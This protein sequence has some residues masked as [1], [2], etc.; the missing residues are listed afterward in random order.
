[1]SDQINN[2]NVKI[3]LNKDESGIASELL[4]L[5]QEYVQYTT[6]NASIFQSNNDSL[7]F[8]KTSTN[9][10]VRIT[11]TDIESLIPTLESMGFDIKGKATEYHFVEGFM[12]ISAI[13][14]MESLT[15]EGMM[16][17]LPVRTA[18]SNVGSVTSQADFVHETERVRA[19]LPTGYDGT[20]VSIGVMSDS[21]NTSGNGSAAQDIVSGDLPAAGVTVL[22]EGPNNSIDEGRAMLQLVHDLAPG[23]PLVFSSVFFGEANFAQ[24]IRDLANPTIGNAQV[25][26]DD[27]V[28]LA[29]PFFQ[30][31]II[32][33]AVDDV[34]TNQGV[35]YFS[36]AGNLARQA[37]ESTNFNPSNDSAGIF[38]DIFHDFNPGAGVDT[39]QLITIAPFSTVRLSLQWDDPF[40]TTNGVDTDLGIFLLEPGTGNVLEGINTNNIANQTPVEIL[41]YTNTGFT[42]L[43]AEIVIPL[44]DGPAPGRIKF[45]NF[46]EDINFNEFGTNSSTIVPHAAAVNAMAVG[47][48]NYY[49]QQ[50]PADF[51]SAGPTTIL[52]NPDGTRKATPEVRLKPDFAAIQDTDTTFFGSDIDGNGFPNFSGTSAA[53]PHAA[54]IA[55]LIQQANPTFTPQ[56]IY[57]RLQSTAT[58]IGIPGRDDLTGVG[59]INAYDAVFGNVIP[60]TLDFNDNFEDG[61]LPIAYETRTTGAGRIQ[62]TGSNAPIGT[63]H[64][65]LDSSQDGINSLN[66]LILHV[67]ATGRSNVELSFAQK[68]FDDEDNLMPATFTGSVNADGVALSVDGTSWFRLFDLT[69]TNSTNTYQNKSI[70]LS[71]FATT[72]GLT[73][74]SDVQI[75][76]QQFDNF[77]TPTDGFAFDNIAVTAAPPINN[78]ELEFSSNSYSVNEDGTPVQAVTISRI[79]GSDGAVSVTLTPSNGTATAPADY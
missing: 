49:D 37:Y 51:T 65:V 45:V 68:E 26:V 16:G 67:N 55:A 8:D 23:S 19:A 76:F 71:Q 41:S 70:N 38:P 9:V 29:E 5:Q 35:T 58:D 50:N 62:V 77:S 12:P 73:L 66:E 61:D 13:S 32:A 79:G 64:V 72:N 7:V 60:A 31:G 25:L 4:N 52:F 27:I 40:Y 20:G 10:L 2:D 22:Q 69:G 36:A 53:A 39:R 46:G 3:S 74:G 54:A 1:M 17:V 33:Q 18:I 6:N 15:S 43:Q 34:V 63:S 47:A 57:N 14:E 75:K 78:G 21:Y 56:Q 42:E 24:Q 30:D 11:A 48:V 59:L 44:F 28:Y